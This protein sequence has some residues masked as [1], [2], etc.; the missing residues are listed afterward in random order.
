MLGSELTAT[1]SD[2]DGSVSGEMWVWVR[3]TDRNTWTAIGGAPSA[4][5]TPASTGVGYYLR[6][7]V[8]YEDGHGPD[9][10]RQAVSEGRVLEFMAPMFPEAMAGVLERSVAEN[11]GPGEAVGALIVAAR[12]PT[13][14]VALMRP[15][16][17]STRTRG[18][19]W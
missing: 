7:T 11:T 10:S 5:Y 19:L 18:R 16:S 15:C 8:S 14:S 2:P 6:V 4:S 12:Q 3:S 9:K 13:R 17:P 1:L